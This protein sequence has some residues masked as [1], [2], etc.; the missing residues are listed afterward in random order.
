MQKNL[1]K[2][3]IKKK[4][5]VLTMGIYILYYHKIKYNYICGR[6]GKGSCKK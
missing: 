4:R 3:K 6:R 2:I 1:I 5:K